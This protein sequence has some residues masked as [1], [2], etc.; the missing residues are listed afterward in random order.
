MVVL[1]N[2]FSA[3]ASEIVSACL[4][5]HDHRALIVGERTWGKG[6]VQNVIELDSGK[7]A[8]KLTTASY[9]RPSGKNI[10]RFPNSKET[11]E[12]GV[13][14]DDGY[15]VK[16]TREDMIAYDEY[17]R[18]RDVFRQDGAA[19]KSTYVDPQLSKALE[20]I[21]QKLNKESPVDEKPA[22]AEESIK[23]AAKKAA[24]APLKSERA[25]LELDVE[26][27]LQKLLHARR[28]FSLA[29]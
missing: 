20:W 23:P 11:D 26:T 21:R 17:R 4:Q 10:H 5:D 19:P 18:E 14:P 1:V 22:D 3:S 15:A 24:M 28:T 6:S 27:V 7:S 2:R 8:L 16:F 12:W 29:M 25:S 9:H 13:M